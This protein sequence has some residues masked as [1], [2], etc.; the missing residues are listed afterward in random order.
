MYNPK[1]D[2]GVDGQREGRVGV[3]GSGKGWGKREIR[4]S[5]NNKNKVQKNLFLKKPL[6]WGKLLIKFKFDIFM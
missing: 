3:G 4:N 5:V 1:T 2:N 6:K